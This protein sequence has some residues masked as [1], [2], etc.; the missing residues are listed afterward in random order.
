VGGYWRPLAAGA[1]LLEELGELA[2]LLGARASSTERMPGT[3]DGQ[4]D[5]PAA[6]KLA[7]E[8][9]D[10]WI[11]TT[12]IADQFLGEVPEPDEPPAQ[13]RRDPGLADLLLAAAPIARIVN[14][15][16]G[17]KTPRIPAPVARP[18]RPS[19]LNGA[20]NEFQD[21]LRALAGSQGLDLRA[22]VE[23][24]LRAIPRIDS[25]RF[26]R[27]EHDPGTAPVLERLR[28]LL[29]DH[30]SVGS[31]RI[32]AAPAWS[33][34]SLRANV[35]A[36]LPSLVAFTKAAAA[37][38]LEG[39]V[40]CAPS[41]DSLSEAENW[42]GQLLSELARYDPPPKRDPAS[43]RDPRISFR[44]GPRSLWPEPRVSLNGAAL[45]V[46]LLSPLYDASHPRHFPLQTVAVFRLASLPPH[47][48]PAS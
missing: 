7:L 11:I 48:P 13:R 29:R 23:H 3:P 47:A 33:R 35:Q 39:Y 42:L 45:Q 43:R 38:R 30:A 9:A 25:G 26:A 37:E 28:P 17:P 18:D 40:V 12:A 15:Y 16:D 24:K 14:H 41:H 4:R 8:L 1:R 10:A 6:E 36:L 44:S 46:T 32:W 20:V 2:E 22:A 21:A 31:A 19:A 5:G 27:S 34:A